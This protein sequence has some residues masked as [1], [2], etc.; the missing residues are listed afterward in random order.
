MWTITSLNTV[1]I[2]R[3]KVTVVHVKMQMEN[4]FRALCVCVNAKS[5]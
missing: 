5:H 1:D 4:F 3:L 2:I